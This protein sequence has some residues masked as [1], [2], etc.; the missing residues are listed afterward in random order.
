MSNE[1]SILFYDPDVEFYIEH[2][3]EF[4][5]VKAETD[6]IIH[7]CRE[8]QIQPYCIRNFRYSTGR[9]PKRMPEPLKDKIQWYLDWNRQYN[10]SLV[11]RLRREHYFEEE[12]ARRQKRFVD[13]ATW[14]FWNGLSIFHRGMFNQLTSADASPSVVKEAE[15]LESEFV[16]V[17]TEER[18]NMFAHL[19]TAAGA[20]ISETVFP[21]A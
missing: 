18:K 17:Y 15:R 8:K 3:D 19:Y 7:V 11:G 12:E 16:R 5:W 10:K 6:A 21:P 1:V 14:E 20:Y 13:I 2:P 9:I 4:E